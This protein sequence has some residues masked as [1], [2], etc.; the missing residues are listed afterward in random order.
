[1]PSRS[2]FELEDAADEAPRLGWG[3]FHPEYKPFPGLYHPWIYVEGD[4]QNDI[5]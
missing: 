2:L 3:L 4:T 1:M 5:N